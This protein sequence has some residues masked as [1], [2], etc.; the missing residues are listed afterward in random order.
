MPFEPGMKLVQSTTASDTPDGLTTELSLPHDPNPEHIDNSQVK[1]AKVVLPEGI[2]INPSAAAGLEACTPTQI[3]IGTK[4]PIGCPAGS[5]L[6]TV[7][8]NVPGLPDGSLTGNFYLGEDEVPITKPPYTVYVSAESERYGIVVRLRGQVFPN[9]TTG[10]LTTTFTENPEQPFS[11]PDDQTQRRA[12]RAAGQ[13]PEVRKIERRDRIQPVHGHG[14]QGTDG[15][16]RS[17]RVPGERCRS[18]SPR[19]RPVKSPPPVGTRPT[20]S[21]S[22]ART[23]SSSCRASPRRCPRA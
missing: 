13:Q 23:A 18:R 9:P 16:V 3:G 19:A 4:N 15:A 10:Q 5:K 2:T 21:R 11:E 12:A 14:G 20:R 8:L 7:A 1:T 6:G 17:H 22:R